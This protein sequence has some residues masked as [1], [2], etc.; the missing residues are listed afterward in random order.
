MGRHAPEPRSRNRPLKVYVTETER[1]ALTEAA[2]SAGLSV[3]DFLRR[4]GLG[5]QVRSILDQDHVH[6]VMRARADLGRVGG[7]LKMWLAERPGVGAPPRSVR[8]LL[9][10]IEAAQDEVRQKV[11]AL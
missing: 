10:R 1:T 6:E 8:A 3:S 2:R 9:D 11:R 5:V 7:L 4:V